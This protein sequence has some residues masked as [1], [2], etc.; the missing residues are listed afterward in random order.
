[1]KILLLLILLTS[2][3]SCNENE[4]ATPTTEATSSSYQNNSYPPVVDTGSVK[5][6]DKPQYESVFPIGTFKSLPQIISRVFSTYSTKTEV[7]KVQGSP[8]L[9]EQL[10]AFEEV[11]YYGNSKIYF[12]GQ[13]VSGIDNTDN[14][15]KSVRIGDLMVS[16]DKIE[17]DYFHFLFDRGDR[18][19][20]KVPY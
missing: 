6:P 10:S 4:Q 15:L 16:P 7:L 3:L 19:S 11:W 20:P 9:K 2:I 8:E 12:K 1:M 18:A 17:Q 13:L 14:N 5:A